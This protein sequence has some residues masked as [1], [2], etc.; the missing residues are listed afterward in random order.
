MGEEGLLVCCDG[1]LPCWYHIPSL[2]LQ[3]EEMAINAGALPARLCGLVSGIARCFRAICRHPSGVLGLSVCSHPLLGVSDPFC[4]VPHGRFANSNGEWNF[5]RGGCSTLLLPGEA[6]GSKASSSVSCGR[7]NW[8]PKVLLKLPNESAPL[9]LHLGW[10]SSVDV[11]R[12]FAFN[13]SE[14]LRAGIYSKAFHTFF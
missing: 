3:K 13:L 6:G 7:V 12:S 9:L 14:S 5:Q 8:I 11:C 10:N 4:K 1:R 2:S